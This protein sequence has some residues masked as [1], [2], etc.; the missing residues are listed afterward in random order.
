MASLR[1]LYLVLAP[2]VRGGLATSYTYPV[3]SRSGEAVSTLTI[4]E[5]WGIALGV[6]EDEDTLDF[7]VSTEQSQSLVVLRA[8]RSDWVVTLRPSDVEWP[9]VAV[10]RDH[11]LRYRQGRDG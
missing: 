3:D 8:L 1:E 5:D 11:F 2:L 9:E 7:T 4:T 6:P 10:A